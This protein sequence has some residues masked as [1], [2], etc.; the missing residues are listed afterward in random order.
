MCQIGPWRQ[1]PLTF[2]IGQHLYISLLWTIRAFSKT[3][4][5]H[6]VN[7]SVFFNSLTLTSWSPL[8]FLSYALS[9]EIEAAA[10][11]STTSPKPRK[12]MVKRLSLWVSPGGSGAPR[13]CHQ[14]RERRCIQQDD[15]EPGW[16]WRALR[17]F[18][19]PFILL[20]W[21]QSICWVHSSPLP[22]LLWITILSCL[23]HSSNI[24][25]VFWLPLTQP[26]IL[27]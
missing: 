23:N 10:D 20:S 16:K 3:K 27:H 19:K 14:S 11:A 5:G 17:S 1:Y 9:C 13:G 2:M 15:L 4:P 18:V 24:F 8:L 26:F 21:T 25:T 7:L 22:S 12:S 6:H